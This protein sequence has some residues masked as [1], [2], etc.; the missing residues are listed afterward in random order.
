MWAGGAWDGCRRR[1]ASGLLVLSAGPAN[2]LSPSAEGYS[3]QPTLEGM[4]DRP[5]QPGD[6][7]FT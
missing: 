2:G 7:A 1:D 3:G 5:G 6:P 4:V